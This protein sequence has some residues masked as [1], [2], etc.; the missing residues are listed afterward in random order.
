MSAPSRVRVTG[1]LAPFADGFCAELSSQGYRPDA[2]TSQVRLMAHLSRWLAAGGLD[3]AVLTPKVNTEFLAARRAHGYTQW[4]SPK[5]LAPLIAY[6]R[7][8]SVVP[9][10][11]VAVES[12][13]DALLARYRDHMVFERAVCRAT[14]HTYVGLVRPF[15]VRH[16]LGA[17]LDLAGSACRD[18]TE[19]VRAS[20]TGRS[21]ASAKLLVTAMRSLLGFLFIDG[22]IQEPLASCVPSVAGWR[23]AGLPRSLE[24]RDVPRLLAACDRRT[25]TG[26]RN[27]AI[28][29]MLVRLG[30]RAGEICALRLD[31]FDW[32]SGEVVIHGKGNRAERLPLPADVGEAVV[33]YLQRARPSTATSRTVFVRARAPH[34]GITSSA[35]YFAVCSTAEQAGLGRLGPHALRHTAA[36]QMVRAGAALPEVGQ[37]LRHRRLLTTA[38]YAKVDRDRLRQVARPWPGGAR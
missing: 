13:A 38:I 18:V 16:V 10:A 17:G 34:R 6:L 25:R 28:L 1:P 9:L 21:S 4:L 32:R 27:F 35:V 24:S 20:C 22:L 37:V 12:A 3:V 7:G 30:L 19:F 2:A 33:D 23:H 36:V 8:L 15:V 5:A 31:D 14:A 26:Q 11:P 29:T